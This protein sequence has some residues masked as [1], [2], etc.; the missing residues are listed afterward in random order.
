MKGPCLGW[1]KGLVGNV[2]RLSER[3]MQK[4]KALFLSSVQ[5]CGVRGSDKLEHTATEALG[6][7]PSKWGIWILSEVGWAV[8][9]A[10]NR[11]FLQISC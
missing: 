7:T 9:Y 8:N 11:P 1:G 4:T 2:Y 10:H 5:G 3:T 6:R